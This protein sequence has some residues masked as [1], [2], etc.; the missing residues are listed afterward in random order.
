MRTALTLAALV[1]G[2]LPARPALA[3]AQAAVVVDPAGPIR[4]VGEALA[5]VA[6]GG[7][8]TLLAGTYREPL[9]RVT[10]PVTLLGDSGAVLEGESTGSSS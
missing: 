4:T 6:P 8:I 2:A 10:R 1:A 3:A 7:T 9:L 5:R